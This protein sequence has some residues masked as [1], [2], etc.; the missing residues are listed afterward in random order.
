MFKISYVTFFGLVLLFFTACGTEPIDEPVEEP[1]VYTPQTIE[2][3]LDVP[4]PI[5]MT[6]TLVHEG[7]SLTITN[8][9]ENRCPVDVACY[10]QGFLQFEGTVASPDGTTQEMEWYLLMSPDVTVTYRTKGEEEW[11]SE[12]MPF[13]EAKLNFTG[14]Y[15][16]ENDATPLQDYV[17]T[18]S[19]TK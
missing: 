11:I 12:A 13:G 16:S 19:L 2:A 9:E 14:L 15:P 10:W 17:F 6:D 7:Y 3:S 5:R 8:I 1:E 4:I 18:V